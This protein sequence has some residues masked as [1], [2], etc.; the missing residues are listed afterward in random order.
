MILFLNFLKQA[1]IYLIVLGGLSIALRSMFLAD[2]ISKKKIYRTI[3]FLSILALTDFLSGMVEGNQDHE[4]LY[5]FF[6]FTN[7]CLKPMLIIVLIRLFSERFSKLFVTMIVISPIAYFLSVSSYG[8]QDD[9]MVRASSLVPDFCRAVLLII[10]IVE[11]VKYINQRLFRET[12]LLVYILANISVTIALDIITDN[13]ILLNPLYIINI[14]FYLLYVHNENSKVDPLTRAFNRQS[15]YADVEAV[16]SKINGVILLDI[17]NFKLI[18]DEYGHA[19]GDEV[20]VL[21]VKAVTNLLKPGSRLY[22]TGGDEFLVLSKKDKETIVQMAD[23]IR[24][25]CQKIG[26]PCAVG[27]SLQNGDKTIDNLLKEADEKM[28]RDKKIQKKRAGLTEEE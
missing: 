2:K 15:F 13:T 25:E 20:L 10:L 21:I 14:M 22:R 19:K 11:A 1:Y 17:N 24:L 5:K 4:L 26:Y 12:K 27:V 6:N 16:G 7:L 23:R 8:F 9:R 3:F 28:Y 18:N